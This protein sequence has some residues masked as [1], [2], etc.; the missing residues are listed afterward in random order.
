MTTSLSEFRSV[1]IA[2]ILGASPL[3]AQLPTEERVSIA[4]FTSQKSLERGRYLFRRGDPAQ[5]LFIVQSGAIN[6]HRANEVG[7][8]HVIQVIRA[9]ESFGEGFLASNEPCPIDG[10]ALEQSEVVVIQKLQLLAFLRRHPETLLRFFAALN[11]YASL[12]LS[13]VEDLA[14]AD[15]ETRVGRWLVRHCADPESVE[16]SQVHLQTTKRLL[17]AELGTVSE[18]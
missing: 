11:T 16:P 15:V 2:N 6:I 17:A 14:L 3:F 13:Q 4:E 7:K 1:V 10:R 9:G 8:L 12:L 18:T 5:A